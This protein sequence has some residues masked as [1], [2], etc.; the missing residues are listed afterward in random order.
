MDQGWHWLD[1]ESGTGAWFK[2]LITC[3]SLLVTDGSC[4]FLLLF[5]HSQQASDTLSQAPCPPRVWLTVSLFMYRPP[6]S[7]VSMSLCVY[8]VYKNRCEVWVMIKI[9]NEMDSTAQIRRSR[10]GLSAAGVKFITRLSTFS[11]RSEWDL[12]LGAK[13]GS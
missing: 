7:W 9:E 12:L 2:S 5:S 8:T 3:R 1:L 6:L 10:H 13:G 4:S 11:S